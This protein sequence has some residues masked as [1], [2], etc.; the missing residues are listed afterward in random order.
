[1]CLRSLSPGSLKLLRSRR[2][3]GSPFTLI[4]DAIFNRRP[5]FGASEGNVRVY[6]LLL[7][8]DYGRIP[9]H[10]YDKPLTQI[11]PAAAAASLQVSKNCLP[12]H[13]VAPV[14]CREMSRQ[15]PT[16]RHDRNYIPVPVC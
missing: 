7:G 16:A 12:G 1:M 10:L 4:A 3:T 11:T 14:I 5:C 13:G 15:R 9:K 6:R 2:I 8:Q